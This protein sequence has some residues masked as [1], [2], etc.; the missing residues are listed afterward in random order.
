MHGDHAAMG[1]ENEKEEGERGRQ[2]ENRKGS[3]ES[4]ILSWF[5]AWIMLDLICFPLKEGMPI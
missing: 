2:D 4:L 5:L 1:K 3:H